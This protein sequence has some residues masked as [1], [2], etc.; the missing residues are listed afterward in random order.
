MCGVGRSHTLLA[1]A[2]SV[3]LTSSCIVQIIN[4]L[5]P[6]LAAVLG[7]LRCRVSHTSL[8]TMAIPRSVW[9]ASFL[10]AFP[11][12]RS[13][14]KRSYGVRSKRFRFA[15]IQ[16]TQPCLTPG[17]IQ[18]GHHYLLSM[19]RLIVVRP[20]STLPRALRP[21]FCTFGTPL[22]PS[23]CGSTNFASI[24]AMTLRRARKCN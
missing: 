22:Q 7:T 14:T 1:W 19:I 6:S 10:S 12:T 24:K 23:H 21:H 2:I 9:C 5:L 13:Q 17:A 11:Q 3:F 16:N 20:H 15:T 18:V 4:R 8:W